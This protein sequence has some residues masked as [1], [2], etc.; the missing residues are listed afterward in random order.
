MSL[1]D[2]GVQTGVGIGGVL[3]RCADGGI[4][5]GLSDRICRKI[6][7]SLGYQRI[8]E[9]GDLR[10][11]SLRK[12]QEKPSPTLTAEETL[13]LLLLLLLFRKRFPL[14]KR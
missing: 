4:K 12:L 10:A 3:L 1:P 8:V 5:F 14:E 11:T 9:E 6:N 2:P 13:W 7:F